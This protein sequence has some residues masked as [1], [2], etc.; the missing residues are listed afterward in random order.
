[1]GVKMF[2]KIHPVKKALFLNYTIGYMGIAIITNTLV[3]W[4]MYFYS[5]P[6]SSGRV[7]YMPAS[8]FGLVLALGRIFDAITDPLIS[9]WSDN[10]RTPFGRRLPFIIAG[11]LPTVAAFILLW[12]PPVEEQAAANL[13]YLII[14]LGVLFLGLTAVTCPFMALMPE[15]AESPSERMGAAEG[16]ALAHIAGLAAAMLAAAFLIEKYGFQIMAIVLSLVILGSFAVPIF[17]VKEKRRNLAP[18]AYN[19]RQSIAL[20]FQN[21]VFLPYIASLPFFWFGFNIVLTGIPYI[22][23]ILVGLDESSTGASLVLALAVSL[24]SFPFVGRLSHTRGKKFTFSAT[25]ILSSLLLLTI[26]GIGRWPLPLPTVWQGMIIIALAG[27][28]LAGLFILPNALLADIV[29]DDARRTGERREAV[30]YGM[31]GLVM[32]STIGLSAFFLGILLDYFGSSAEHPLGVVLIGP[33]AAL[34]LLLGVLIFRKY[35][36]R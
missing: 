22:I 12:N 19:F 3:T 35:P 34:C 16:L 31:Q 27:I 14:V 26:A 1:M 11:S 25:M 10:T 2:F 4:A 24:I 32:K 8:L 21:K 5:P 15:I 23:T 9:I 18:P 36:L 20:T 30:Y 33:S 13:V 17:S 6:L 7:V 28:P 29:D